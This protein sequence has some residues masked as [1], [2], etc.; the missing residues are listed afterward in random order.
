VEALRHRKLLRFP[1]LLE[2]S[3]KSQKKPVQDWADWTT[4]AYSRFLATEGA[5]ARKAQ[6]NRFFK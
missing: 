5:A 6:I 3:L 1:A 2:D 4:K